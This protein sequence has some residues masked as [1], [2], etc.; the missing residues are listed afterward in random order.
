[1]VRLPW[2]VDM[3]QFKN[4]LVRSRMLHLFFLF[5][6]ISLPLYAQSSG[7]SKVKQ[8]KVGGHLAPTGPSGMPKTAPGVV[9]NT[10]VASTLSYHTNEQGQTVISVREIKHDVSAPLSAMVA[11][12]PEPFQGGQ[13]EEIR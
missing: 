3:P 7:E 8:E 1:M 4:L 6:L 2:R 5:T 9:D 11:L 10:D 13:S 12:K